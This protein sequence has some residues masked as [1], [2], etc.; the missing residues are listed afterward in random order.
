MEIKDIGSL[1][2]YEIKYNKHT[3]YYF[4]NSEEDVDDFLRNERLFSA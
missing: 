2:S 3:E 1:K 4:T